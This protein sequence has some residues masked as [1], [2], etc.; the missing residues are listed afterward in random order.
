MAL[1]D[2]QGDRAAFEGAVRE[3]RQNKS[4]R[5]FRPG[6]SPKQNSTT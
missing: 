4:G 1:A 5:V 3:A 6:R 2:R